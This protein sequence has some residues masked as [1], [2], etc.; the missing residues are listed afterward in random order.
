VRPNVVAITF[1]E[2]TLVEADLVI[3]ADGYRSVVRGPGRG[4]F[5]V[6]YAGYVA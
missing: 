5:E 2:R 6:T 4:T 3:G 1:D